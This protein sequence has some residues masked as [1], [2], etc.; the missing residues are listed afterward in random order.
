MV[1]QDSAGERRLLCSTGDIVSALGK[2]QQDGIG[3][4]FVRVGAVLRGAV[5]K[6]FFESL[7]DEAKRLVA[8]A[9]IEAPECVTALAEVVEDLETE[10]PDARRLEVLRRAYLS[11]AIGDTSG[12]PE[13]TQAL[14]FMKTAR[15]L[16]GEHGLVL[17]CLHKHRHD[18]EKRVSQHQSLN[19]FGTWLGKATAETGIPYADEVAGIVQEMI[20]MRLV[21]GSVD[22]TPTWGQ[23]ENGILTPYAVAFCE[24]LARADRASGQ[25]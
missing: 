14:L 3:G 10:V 6:P 1:T 16:S 7:M 9:R 22:R 15:R 18:F 8:E 11:T 12:D 4:F 21:R 17:G 19:M 23:T 2:L 24:F 20:P 13:G 5:A 25:G